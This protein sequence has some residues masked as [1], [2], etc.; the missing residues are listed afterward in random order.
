MKIA[1]VIAGGGRGK[2]MG[3]KENKLFIEIG[4]TPLLLLTIKVFDSVDIIDEMVITVPADEIERTKALIEKH[5]AGKVAR[6]IAGGPTR[7]SSV[8][9]GI[10]ALAPDTDIVVIHDG[11]RPFITKEIIM[12]AV[13]SLEGCKAVVVGMPVKDT[14]KTVDSSEVVV[15]T[16]DRNLLWQAQTPQVFDAELIKNAYVLAQKSGFEATDDASLVERTGERVKMI[17]GSYENIKVTT[18]EDIIIAEAIL[19]SK[20]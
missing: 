13:G 19:R 10:Q 4:G 20:R 7:Q 2:R 1:A 16:I 11:A 8:S 14:I 5:A 3:S 6:V 15:N 18:P 9:N 17:R 12:R